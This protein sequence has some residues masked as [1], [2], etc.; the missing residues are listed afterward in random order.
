MYSIVRI[1]ELRPVIAFRSAHFRTC[2]VMVIVA[3]ANSRGSIFPVGQSGPAVHSKN[4]NET[5]SRW[6]HSLA[7]VLSKESVDVCYVWNK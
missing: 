1:F 2:T 6:S 4:T 5:I 3:A 7:V